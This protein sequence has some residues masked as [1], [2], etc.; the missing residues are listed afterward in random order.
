MGEALLWLPI[1]IEL[2]PQVLT[3]KNL[4]LLVLALFLGAST[5][6]AQDFS[7]F[8]LQ[9]VFDACSVVPYIEYRNCVWITAG[10][11]SDKMGGE[12]V[13]SDKTCIVPLKCNH[14][15]LNCN[16]NG[17]SAT[18]P[19]IHSGFLITLPSKNIVRYTACVFCKATDM[20]QIP[21]QI[22]FLDDKILMEVP[23]KEAVTK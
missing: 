6:Q 14:D 17:Y 23:T 22:L 2:E 1:T 10:K 12:S 5:A 8:R 3:M 18:R 4:S 7:Q 19:D 15:N 13:C 20:Q 9:K 21:I 11:I 16:A